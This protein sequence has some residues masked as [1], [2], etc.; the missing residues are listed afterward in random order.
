MISLFLVFWV[1]FINYFSIVYF[2][3]SQ[4]GAERD[5]LFAGHTP[6]GYRDQGRTLP[7]PGTWSS[8]LVPPVEDRD[9]RTGAIVCCLPRCPDRENKTKNKEADEP[10]LKGALLHRRPTLRVLA[11]PIALLSSVYL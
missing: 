3:E 7:K 1:S 9:P 8:I 4:G 2:F 10:G 6:D 11:D 5:D